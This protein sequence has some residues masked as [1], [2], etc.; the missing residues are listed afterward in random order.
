MNLV[1]SV[2]NPFL[3]L[4]FGF[5]SKPDP[6]LDEMKQ[7]EC[8]AVMVKKWHTLL[9]FAIKMRQNVVVSQD[10]PWYFYILWG[11]HFETVCNWLLEK[12]IERAARILLDYQI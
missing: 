4:G 12:Y 2:F 3:G 8:N 5:L 9:E 7:N 10:T 1:H 11:S 6:S